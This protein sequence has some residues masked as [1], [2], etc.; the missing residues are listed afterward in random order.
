M[1]VGKYQLLGKLASGGM[2]EVY[3]AKAA[4]P[5]GFEK[6]LVVKRVLPHLA[7]DPSFVEMFFSEARLA[8]LLNHPNI[9][10]IFD[11]GEAEGAYFLA[12]EY[13]DGP[14]LRTLGKRAHAAGMPL[15]VQ[16][17]AKL[18][19]LACEGLAYAHEFVDPGT[20]EPLGL[21]HRDISPDNLLMSSHGTLKVVDF[22]IAKAANQLHHTRSG[23]LKG[24]ISYMAPEQ[25]RNQPLD[26]RAD[27]FALGVVLYEL[28]SG[29]RK[30]FDAEGEVGM[31]QAILHQPPVPIRVRRADVPE[32]LCTI[33]ERALAKERDA[34]YGSCREL[35]ADLERYL[36]T[37][38]EPV[39]ARH[40]AQLVAQLAPPGAA[41]LRKATPSPQGLQPTRAA[42]PRSSGSSEA[43]DSAPAE[44]QARPLEP[45]AVVLEPTSS[46]QGRGRWRGGLA[47]TGLLV[48]L[49]G[50]FL[51][52]GFPSTADSAPAKVTPASAPAEPLALP[53]GVPAPSARPP[54]STPQPA[55]VEPA[56]V[57]RAPEPVAPAPEP[58]LIP[59]MDTPEPQRKP[60]VQA[61]R[62]SFRVT[63]SVPGMVRVNGKLVG[64]APVEVRGVVPGAVDI[65]VF[66]ARV[67]FSKKQTFDVRAGD[68][69]NLV[70]EIG[71]G[72]LQI[73]VRPYAT[74]MLDGK[75]LGQTPLEPIELYE[76]RYQ[77]KL[78]NADLGKEKV[79]EYV[80]R[81]GAHHVFKANMME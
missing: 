10:Q 81:A 68:N 72:S 8:A 45:T 76:G 43:I 12:M 41:A 4:G 30:P 65:E 42:V 29:G 32:S 71:K 17:C 58:A 73:W 9:V 34:R 53:E 3:L 26:A 51:W 59:A 60:S 50:A 11:F 33:L 62:A 39:T 2:A 70:F 79:V 55:P 46:R 16:L 77:L 74:V 57:A 25:L 61:R 23:V 75:V 35:Q 66:D 27:V 15:P 80:V 18:V 49:L 47:V 54:V 6:T 69:G 38:G 37:T 78:V 48:A 44:Q 20:G 67:G 14:N 52:R 5:R 40:L 1:T 21:V 13:I 56:A 28:L 31:I 22:G 63:S 24:K 64:R 7:E 19:S 36:Y